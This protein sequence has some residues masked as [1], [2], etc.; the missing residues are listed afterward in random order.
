MYCNKRTYVLSNIIAFSSL[1]RIRNHP[2]SP[3]THYLHLPDRSTFLAGYARYPKRA[4]L[5]ELREIIPFDAYVLRMLPCGIGLL[6]D[7]VFEGRLHHLLGRNSKILRLAHRYFPSYHPLRVG[8]RG[9]GSQVIEL[10]RWGLSI[11]NLIWPGSRDSSTVLSR[12]HC[13]YTISSRSKFQTGRIWLL[14]YVVY[15]TDFSFCSPK[16]QAIQE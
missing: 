1:A 11:Q 16:R 8:L 14:G 10:R 5:I 4:E 2:P 7:D 15:I 12:F 9:L 3:Y 6:Y 13:R